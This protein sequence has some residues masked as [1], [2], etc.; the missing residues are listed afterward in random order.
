MPIRTVVLPKLQRQQSP[1]SL[2]RLPALNPETTSVLRLVHVSL[3]GTL[4]VDGVVDDVA[5]ELKRSKL[6]VYDVELVQSW[7]R[8]T[9]IVL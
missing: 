8:C 7:R 1:S 9:V 2:P 6:R 4:L 3:D 5:T